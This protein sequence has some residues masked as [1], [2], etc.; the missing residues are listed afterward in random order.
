VVN[1]ARFL[2]ANLPDAGAAGALPLTLPDRVAQASA[3]LDRKASSCSLAG[4]RVGH[5]T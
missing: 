5:P 3:W 4:R 2:E 1:S